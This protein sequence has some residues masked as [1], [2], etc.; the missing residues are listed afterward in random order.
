MLL[1]CRSPPAAARGTS[2]ERASGHA[3]RTAAP[4]TCAAPLTGAALLCCSSSALCLSCPPTTD[5][6]RATSPLP[7]PPAP[8]R[9]PVPG[10]LP[11]PPSVRPRTEAR[12]VHRCVTLNARRSPHRAAVSQRLQL[13]SWTITLG[14]ADLAATTHS[15]SLVGEKSPERV[16]QRLARRRVTDRRP[17]TPQT[18]VRRGSLHRRS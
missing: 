7:V 11:T 9:Y 12:S 2:A 6:R 18:V 14:L 8:P 1:L 16:A 13:R 15:C 5:A 17:A 10:V 4:L 3:L